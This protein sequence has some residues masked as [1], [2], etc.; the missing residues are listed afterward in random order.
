MSTSRQYLKPRPEALA[1]IDHIVVLMLENRS[2]DNLLGWLYEDEEPLRGQHFEGLHRGLS[3]P[4][5][6]IDPDGIRFTETVPIRK[7]GEP[8]PSR[9]GRKRAALSVDYRLPDP[10]PGEGFKHTNRQLFGHWEVPSL[11]P[12]EPTMNGFVNDYADAMLYGTSSFGD[13]P[14]DPRNIMVCYTPEQV[15]VLS[16]LARSFAVCDHWFCSVPSQTLPNRDFV[17]AATSGGQVNNRPQPDC[18][19]PTIFNRIQQAIE[20]GRHDLSWRVYSGTQKGRPFSLTRTIMSALHDRAFDHGFQAIEDFYRDASDGTLP[21]YAFLEPQFS[22]PGQNDQHPNADIRPGEQLI[23]D[24]YNAVRDS[25]LWEKTLLVITYDEHGGCYDHVRPPAGAAHPDGHSGGPGQ[26]G[27]RFNRFG[28]RVPTVLVSPWIPFGTIARPYG[29]TPFDHTSVIATVRNR[30]A[31]GPP[32]T[33]RD[34]KA[35]DLSCVLTL[36]APRTDKPTVYPLP[37]EPPE[38]DNLHELHLVLADALARLRGSGRVDEQSLIA[39]IHEAY[40]QHFHG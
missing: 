6:N 3:N 9:H 26:M 10:D 16:Q 12:P 21:S 35:P 13:P 22:G 29:Y 37:Y 11:Y 5:D 38:R 17:H 34:A 20:S 14:S 24:V 40:Q 33:A 7:N 15:P 39:F 18:P 31:L 32:L 23:A 25:P 2:F 8:L 4:L 30:F 28:V 36:G 1:R 19:A 27:F